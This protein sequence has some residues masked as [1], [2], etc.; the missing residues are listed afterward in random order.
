MSC[1]SVD[2]WERVS[3]LRESPQ[4]FL[5]GQ[6]DPRG[7]NKGGIVYTADSPVE[8]AGFSEIPKSLL[9]KKA[10]CNPCSLLWIS[11]CCGCSSHWHKFHH[12]IGT[13][14]DHN[15]CHFVMQLQ[16]RSTKS[17]FDPIFRI[18]FLYR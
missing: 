9:G 18:T 7:G 6:L 11:L 2:V 16:V 14:A 4:L 13:K 5:P 3:D 10:S 1:L 8:S 15:E 17:S 12:F